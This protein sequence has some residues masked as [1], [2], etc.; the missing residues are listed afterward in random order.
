MLPIT[1]LMLVLHAGA[2]AALFVFSWPAVLSAVVLS[3]LIG[4]LGVGIGYHRLLT[5]RSFKVTK[6]VEYAPT[7][8]GTGALTARH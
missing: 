5:H 6:P 2:I 3:W 8:P 4:G 1:L 7:V